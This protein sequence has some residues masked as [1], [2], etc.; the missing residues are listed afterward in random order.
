MQRLEP[1]R[2]RRRQKLRVDTF[3]ESHPNVANSATRGGTLVLSQVDSL[4]AKL[5]KS[6]RGTLEIAKSRRNSCV[7]CPPVAFTSPQGAFQR[8]S[9]VQVVRH[10]DRPPQRF[11]AQKL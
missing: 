6:R 9:H 3:V 7:E 11:L 2:S 5:L 8:S 4:V 1:I 10:T